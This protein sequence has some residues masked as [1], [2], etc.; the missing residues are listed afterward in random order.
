MDEEDLEVDV[1]LVD[2]LVEKEKLVVTQANALAKSVQQM[3]TQEKRLL[4]LAISHIRQTDDKFILYRI[5]IATIKEYLDLS[6][7][8]T[9][10]R[11]REIT[12]KLLGRVIEVQKENDEWVQFQ[13]VSYCHYRPKGT[14]DMPEAC[15]DIRMHDRLRPLLLNLKRQFG[16]FYMHQIAPMQSFY[17]T[18]MFEILY[19]SAMFVEDENKFLKPN[20]TMSVI[21][22]KKRLGLENSYKDFKDFRRNILERAQRDC[23]NRSP[24][25][26][27]WEEKRRGR[28]QKVVSLDFT[29]APNPKF[30]DAEIEHKQL[31]AAT[32]AK[33]VVKQ[34]KPQF[35]FDFALSS[36][37]DDD[38]EQAIEMI[39][40]VPAKDKQK[41]LD[42]WNYAIG[43]GDITKNNLRYLKALALAYKKGEFTFTSDLPKKREEEQ[44]YWEEMRRKEEE[45]RR[46]ELDRQRA[47]QKDQKIRQIVASWSQEEKTKFVEAIEGDF[48][49]E[50]V[51][52]ELAKGKIS[53]MAIVELEKYLAA[54]IV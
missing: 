16:S 19:Y 54:G 45:K 44:R 36:L 29:I 26:F 20:F 21:D 46:W 53:K 17:S 7:K 27:T 30:T 32:V 18:R 12:R 23:E 5:P 52:D 42:E 47:E 8:D 3:T 11:V 28:G 51:R 10:M 31:P 37:T 14:A 34:P 6:S 13:W 38:K 1:M 43:N 40:T 39:K 50:Y 9:H 49:R 25:V 35:F 33:K 48:M 41:I 22:L 2:K 24:I 4:L 15:L